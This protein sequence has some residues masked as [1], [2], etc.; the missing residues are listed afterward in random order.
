M[1]DAAWS[2]RGVRS[3]QIPWLSL[4]LVAL[5]AAAALI[6]PLRPALLMVLIAVY[7]VAR[8]RRLAS[9][10]IAAAIPVAAILAWGALPQ[11]TAAP[12]A[13]QCADLLAPP[14]VWRFIEAGVGLLAAGLLIVDRRAGGRELG[15]RLGSRRNVLLSVAAVVVLTPVALLAGNLLGSQAL[16]GSFFGTYRLDLG[17]PAALLPA[18][19]FAISNA[20][21][22]ELAY[23][24]TLRTWMAPS[25]G[26]LGANLAQALVFGLAHSGDDFVG[27]VAPTAVAMLAAGFVAGVVARRSS[28]LLFVIAVHAA[29]DIP[30]F[31]YWAC[32]V[33]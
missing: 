18:A 11:P 9:A 22:E 17:Q 32:R 29:F 28:S 10:P 1:R 24:G 25:L 14:A 12:G 21:A 8:W 33:A 30:L 4:L 19:V 6:R 16:G 23:R 31:F 7:G 27:P 26:V 20:V 2:G 3:R 15:L 5:L 13:A